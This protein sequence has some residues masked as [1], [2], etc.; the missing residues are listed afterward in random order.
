MAG[1][2]LFH[3][4]AVAVQSPDWASRSAVELFSITNFSEDFGC[5]IMR[6]NKVCIVTFKNEH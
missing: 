4:L 2:S 3:A 6:C 1:V 5:C